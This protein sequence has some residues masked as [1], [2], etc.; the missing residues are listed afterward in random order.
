M[1]K[2]VKLC[3]CLIALGAIS[4]ALTGC[5]NSNADNT[6]KA[7]GKTEITFWAAPNP[8]Q[9]K[10]W[11]SMADKFEKENSDIKVVVSQMKESPSSEATIQ[12]AIASNTAP[13]LSENVSRSFASQLSESKALAN[14]SDFDE[15]KEILKNRDMNKTA[16]NWKFSDGN[17]Y[18]VPMYTNPVLTMWRTD[19]LDEIGV[20]K[21][22]QTYSEVIEV[23]K[24][25]KE[26]YPDKE[27]LVDSKLTDPTAWRRWFDFFPFYEAACNG[28]GFIE[29]D[30]LIADDEAVMSTLDFFTQL[31]QEKLLVTAEATDTFEKG[32]SILFIGNP[33]RFPT[34]SQKFPDFKYGE[35]WTVSNM[36]TPDEAKSEQPYTFADTKG[37]VMYNQAT[38]DEKAAGMKFLDFV[39]SKPEH[40]VEWMDTTSMVAS[41]DSFDDEVFAKAFENN[42]QMTQF[43]EA[44]TR[45]LPSMDNP[46]WNEIQQSFS[47]KVFVPAVNAK[48]N[49]N[50]NWNSFKDSVGGMLK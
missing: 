21:V 7:D 38:D 33:S 9:L 12:A 37:V 24:K 30:K 40:D 41:R 47:E 34:W 39:F 2:I 49:N 26:K 20:D 48:G 25:L 8:P 13:T 17:Q 14:F 31:K 3:T 6:S 5:G 4:A 11:K 29:E 46:K 19:I 36:I 50:E 28:A 35:Q 10:F 18:V 32:E 22:P 43:L 16:E 15:Y 27:L 42:S 45:A 44:T 1:K 23:G